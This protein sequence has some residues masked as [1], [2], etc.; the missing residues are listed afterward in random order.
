M[1]IQKI[2]VLVS[3][4]TIFTFSNT[5]HETRFKERMGKLKTQVCKI[6]TP[7]RIVAIG[8]PVLLTLWIRWNSSSQD[9]FNALQISAQKKLPSYVKLK[10]G[11]GGYRAT[12]NLFAN[13]ARV[14]KADEQVVKSFNMKYKDFRSKEIRTTALYTALAGLSGGL[15]HAWK[16]R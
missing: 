7:G 2:I 12:L 14:S 4:V 16:S 5:G 11:K 6:L 10:K 8:A 3:A 15:L 1:K 9:A 13:K